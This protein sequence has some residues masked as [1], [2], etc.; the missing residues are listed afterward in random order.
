MDKYYYFIAELPYLYFGKEAAITIPWF[1]DEAQKW[2]EPRDYDQLGKIDYLNC[3]SHPEDHPVVQAYK[4]FES[5]LRR[6]LAGWRT[7]Q[8]AGQDYKPSTFPLAL[9]REGNP[10][11]VERNLLLWRWRFLESLEL[12]HH[13]DFGFIV[14]YYLKL[15]LLQKFFT[16]N[17]E[18]GKE[19]YQLYTKIGL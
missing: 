7:A 3:E 18:I 4:G 17:K 15:Q 13:F 8:K 6:D 16:F 2:L 10:L 11:N 5:N 12:G 14:L 1:L 9:V 19:K